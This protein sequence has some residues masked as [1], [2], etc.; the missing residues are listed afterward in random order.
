MRRQLCSNRSVTTINEQ[1]GLQSHHLLIVYKVVDIE[2]IC[3]PVFDAGI[4]TYS[5]NVPPV[6]RSKSEVIGI[7]NGY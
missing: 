3:P 1:S 4:I 6:V 7:S 2:Q 5:R